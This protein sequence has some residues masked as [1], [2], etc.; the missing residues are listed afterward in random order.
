MEKLHKFDLFLA[1]AGRL[2]LVSVIAQNPLIKATNFL[3]SLSA[4]CFKVARKGEFFNNFNMEILFV[5]LLFSIPLQFKLVEGSQG[6]SEL[7]CVFQ[8]RPNNGTC[9]Q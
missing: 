7:Y 4:K 2:K 9:D 6:K 1:A 5:K 8:W 3:F